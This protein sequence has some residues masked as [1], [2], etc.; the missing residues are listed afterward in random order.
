VLATLAL[1]Y[2]V[3]RWNGFSDALMYIT[4]PKY[5]PI[6]LKLWQIINNLS[7]IETAAQEGFTA[8][9]AGEGIK[10]ASVMFATIP[11]LLV[12]P[13]LQRY[14]IAGVTVGAVKG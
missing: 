12:Y 3:G 7:A 2:A 5:F 11:I 8:P 9:T 6:Q 10:A 1:F 4:S 14:F 13:W